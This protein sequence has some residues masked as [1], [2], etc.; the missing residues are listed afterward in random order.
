MPFQGDKPEFD[1]SSG[2]LL[3]DVGRR[4]ERERESIYDDNQVIAKFIQA[5]F[6]SSIDQHSPPSQFQISTSPSFAHRCPSVN[7]TLIR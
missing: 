3:M 5:H 1:A 2:W 7:Q 4:K 6:Y